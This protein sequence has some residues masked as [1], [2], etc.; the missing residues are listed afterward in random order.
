M[1]LDDDR[2]VLPQVPGQLVGIETLLIVESRYLAL[3]PEGR[4]KEDDLFSLQSGMIAVDPLP[5]LLL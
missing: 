3:A 5:D 1:M 4:C 2:I